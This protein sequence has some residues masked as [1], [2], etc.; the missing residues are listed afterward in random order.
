M[1]LEAKNIEKHIPLK[2]KLIILDEFGKN[3]TTQNLADNIGNWQH[4]HSGL[5][6]I[7]GGADGI[8]ADLKQ[9]AD[10]KMRLSSMTL[11]H[12][13]AKLLLVEQLYRAWSI[14][15]NHPYHRV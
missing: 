5:C 14:L 4:Q 15:N 2:H 1:L 8:H 11:P 12:G 9:K 7:I 10:Y 6:F 3:D 13:F